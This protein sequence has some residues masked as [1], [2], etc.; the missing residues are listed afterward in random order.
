MTL[1]QKAVPG[2]YVSV[3]VTDHGEG[4]DASTLRRAF[5]PFFTTKAKGTGMGLSFVAGLLR[6]HHAPILVTSDVVSGTS[7]RFWIMASDETP[8]P[9]ET[10]PSA[11]EQ[12][13]KNNRLLLVD[14]D[15]SV[16]CSTS[17]VLEHW[18]FEVESVASGNEA[19][20]LFQNSKG[21]FDLA[22]VDLFMPSVDGLAVVKY[23]K[24]IEP[25]F[26][27]IISTGN[28][29]DRRVQESLE[30]GAACCLCKPFTKDNLREALDEIE[31]NLL[32]RSEKPN[33]EETAW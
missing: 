7:V 3:V 30:A 31:A 1:R 8:L 17:I 16:R 13:G 15:D 22:I 14:D 21:A 2:N 32:S 24:L 28:P 20:E 11:D 27:I 12:Y 26:P 33:I 10:C 5:D 4:M 19:I 18:G 23:M 25:G 6:S 29:L 9:I